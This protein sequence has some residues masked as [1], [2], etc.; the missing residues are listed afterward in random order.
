MEKVVIFDWGGVI[1]KEYPNHYCDRDAIVETFT[2]F[3]NSLTPEEAHHLY[4]ET[5]YD[6]KGRIIST[7]N[8]EDSKY[9][10]YLRIKETAKLDVDYDTF[11]KEFTNNYKKV[12]KYED[13]VNYIYS[14]KGRVKLCLFS[15]LIFICLESLKKHIDLNTF[16]KVFLSYEEGFTKSHIEAFTNVNGKINGD[17]YDVLFI[18]NNAHNLENAKKVGWNT[19][20]AIGDEI[21]KIKKIVE[22]FL[23]DSNDR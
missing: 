15:D 16:D 21:D 10:W 12:D 17:N 19:C 20:L 6:E 18:D 23:G 2:K 3:N 22:D 9:K 7:L 11:I 5:L 4:R 1:L 13:V 14:L 8:D